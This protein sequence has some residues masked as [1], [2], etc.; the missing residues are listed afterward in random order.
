MGQTGI[1]SISMSVKTKSVAIVIP[2]F[3]RFEPVER[4]FDNLES[5]SFRNFAIFLVDHGNTDFKPAKS[6]SFPLQI[7]KE[8]SDLWF[9]G[10]A[11]AGLRTVYERRQ[12]F[13][14]CILLNDDVQVPDPDWLETMLQAVSE[15]TI[16]SCTAVNPNHQ[17]IYSG[18]VLERSKFNFIK[19]DASQ[20]FE[21]ISRSP[22]SCDTLPTRGLCFP[23]SLIKKVGFLNERY[24]P[25]YGSDYEWTTRAK[26]HGFTLLMLRTVYIVTDINPHF[27][28][29][30]G[31]KIY[32]KSR[33][34][35]FLKDFFNPHVGGNFFQILHFG[36]LTFRFPYSLGYVLYHSSRKIGGFLYVNYLHKDTL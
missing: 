17:V 35:K 3:N 18:L 36:R 23:L 8:S 34:S 12:E 26:N 32:D 10:A 7:I 11:N 4:L 2:I 25:H 29:V 33:I 21:K 16:V 27:S 6:R 9:T 5:Q 1:Q 22:I 19:I 24:L 14:Y 15:D 13:T 30:S 20:A 28:R 31:R